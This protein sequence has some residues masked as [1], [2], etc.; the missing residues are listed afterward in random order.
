MRPSI[1]AFD[2]IVAVQIEHFNVSGPNDF[3]TKLR[4][5]RHGLEPFRSAIVQMLNG[6]LQ[7]G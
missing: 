6:Y 5:N 4:A 2:F 3:T 1:T 7:L